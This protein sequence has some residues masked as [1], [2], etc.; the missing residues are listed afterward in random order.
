MRLGLL[1]IATILLSGCVADPRLPAGKFDSWTSTAAAPWVA[2]TASCGFCGGN[3]DYPEVNLTLVYDNGD[4]LWFDYGFGTKPNTSAPDI[5]PGASAFGAEIKQIPP[6][7]DMLFGE[8]DVTIHRARSATIEGESWNQIRD[9]YA[10]A[11]REAR[12]PGQPT[13]NCEDCG[14][15]KV[16]LFGAKELTVTLFPKDEAWSE[17]GNFR[18]G[19]SWDEI[20]QRSSVIRNWIDPTERR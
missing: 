4:V 3:P 11:I 17:H 12:D 7:I 10:D 9:G 14:G 2:F 13:Y 6:P 5:R 20:L 8:S 19:D 16:R 15:Y 1:A 18:R